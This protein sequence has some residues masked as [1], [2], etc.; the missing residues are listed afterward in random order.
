[1]KDIPVFDKDSGLLIASVPGRGPVGDVLVSTGNRLL[2]DLTKGSR[3]GTSSLLRVAQLRR[4]RP[5]VEPEPIRGNVDT[6]IQKVERGE[7]DAVVLAEA[8]LV[9]LGITGRISERL[10]IEDFMPAPG[11]GALAVVARRD[12]LEVIEMLKSIEHPPTRAE[13]EAERGAVRIFGGGC[14][15][16]R[17]AL[18][19]ARGNRIQK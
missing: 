4:A 17:G 14:K 9:R 15:G 16:P 11:Q 5:D 12:D 18:G 1:M 13:I 19:R 10:A 7:F 8:G 6:R 2:K 3:I